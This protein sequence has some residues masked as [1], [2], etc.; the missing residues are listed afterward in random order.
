M[1]DETDSI[2]VGPIRSEMIEPTGAL[3]DSDTPKSP[4]IVRPSHLK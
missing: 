1:S 2:S 4:L 3:R